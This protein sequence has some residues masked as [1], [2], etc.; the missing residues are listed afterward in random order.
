MLRF[1]LGLLRSFG[2]RCPHCHVGKV[3]RHWFAIN[4]KC[5]NCGYVFQAEPGDFWGGIVFAYTYA[6]V[7][8]FGLAAILI[9]FELGSVEARV[10]VCALFIVVAVL[11]V[12]PWTRSNWITVMYLTRGQEKEYRPPEKA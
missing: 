10:Y 11:A 2:L 6:G 1:V 5:S 7:L 9:H 8:A 12:H 3:M 4:P